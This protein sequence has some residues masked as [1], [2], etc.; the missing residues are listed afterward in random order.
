MYLIVAEV[1]AIIHC[2]LMLLPFFMCCSDCVA[3][4]IATMAGGIA[5]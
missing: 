4:V 2:W 1:I 3:D 5:I